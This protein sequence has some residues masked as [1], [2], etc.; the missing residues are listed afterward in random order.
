MDPLEPKEERDADTDEDLLLRDLDRL[1]V[2]LLLQP[3]NTQISRSVDNV[4]R[5]RVGRAKGL[6]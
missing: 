6:A 1:R 3:C 4:S 2:P 5:D